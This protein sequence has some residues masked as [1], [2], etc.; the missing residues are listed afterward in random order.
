[1]IQHDFL[2]ILDEQ[3]QKGENDE[4]RYTPSHIFHDNVGGIL[5]S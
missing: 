1:M 5:T 3:P 2:L 4:K